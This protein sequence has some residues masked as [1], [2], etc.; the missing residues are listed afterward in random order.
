VWIFAS[1]HASLQ[2][3]CEKPNGK[4]WKKTERGVQSVSRKA[5]GK[6]WGTRHRTWKVLSQELNLESFVLVKGWIREDFHKKKKK[7]KKKKATGTK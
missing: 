6:N 3:A 2:Q 7:K 1:Q 4:R 5:E